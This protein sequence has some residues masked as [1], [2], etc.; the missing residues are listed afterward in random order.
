[1]D[2]LFED[3]LKLAAESKKSIRDT[4]EL[5]EGM[6]WTQTLT[7]LGFLLILAA[8]IAIVIDVWNNKGSSIQTLSA[9]INQQTIQL[10]TLNDE[11]NGLNTHKA[12]QP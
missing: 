1:M 2:S 11:L 5:R 6:R 12:K 8:F 7:Y 10:N 4:K 3:V 9:Q